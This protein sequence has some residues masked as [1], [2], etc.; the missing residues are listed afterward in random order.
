MWTVNHFVESWAKVVNTTAPV[1]SFV[2]VIGARFSSNNGTL[3][4]G[5]IACSG[6]PRTRFQTNELYHDVI[7]ASS[8]AFLAGQ[9]TAPIYLCTPNP[10]KKKWRFI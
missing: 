2:L 4:R 5:M 10:E 7:A 1:D 3:L 9:P 6:D 8:L